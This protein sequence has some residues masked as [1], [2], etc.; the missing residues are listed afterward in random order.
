MIRKLNIVLF[1][2]FILQF[3]QA[4]MTDHGV[5]KYG[6]EWI[7][8]G[9]TYYKI[10]IWEDGIY[11]LDFQTLKN[12]GISN[13]I[14][15]SSL[16]LF[17]NGN[18]IPISVNQ[19]NVWSG[20]DF[21]TFNGYYNKS[22]I[23][24]YSFPNG[25]EDIVNP[26]ASMYSDTAA[27]FLTINTQS[28]NL[29][30]VMIS[31]DLTNLPPP[32]PFIY[33]ISSLDFKEVCNSKTEYSRYVLGNQVIAHAYIN[34]P[35]TQGKGMI[36]SGYNQTYS[37]DCPDIT[38]TS[39]LPVYTLRGVTNPGDINLN[40]GHNLK[41]YLGSQLMFNVFSPT[42]KVMYVNFKYI[43]T[44]RVIKAVENRFT[45]V[46]D[47]GLDLI[48]YG[49]LA[50][51][52]T[53]ALE[54]R[55]Q[56]PLKFYLNGNG[57]E[58]Y[59]EFNLNSV[60][61]QNPYLTDSLGTWMMSGIIDA[62]KLK[63]KL[64]PSLERQSLILYVN[65]S[66]V[67]PASNIRLTA[68]RTFNNSEATYIIV[69]HP[70]LLNNNNGPSAVEEYAGYRRSQPGGGHDVDVV[71]VYDLYNSF[72][73]GLDYNPMAVKNYAN[74]IVLNNQAKFL[75]IIGRGRDY[76][77]IRSTPDLTTA[78][79]KGYGVPSFGDFG[80]DNLLV[81]GSFDRLDM[82]LA[83]GRLPAV[84]QEE[85]RVYLNKIKASDLAYFAPGPNEDKQWTKQII[86]LNG[87]NI[88]GSDQA[89]IK[90]GQKEA[91]EIIKSNKLA[92][93]VTT[94]VKGSNQT[95][96]T[97]SE[98]YFKLVNEGVSIV[99][100]FGHGALSSLEYPIDIPS[101][102]TN[103]PRLPI[104]IIKGCKTGNCQ[105]DGSSIPS[106]FLYED[107]YKTT[108]FRAVI[109]SISDSELYSL[110]SM[111]KQFYTLL[112]G[113]LYGKSFGEVFQRTFN[114]PGLNTS[115]ESM[116]QLFVG[117]PAISV[118]PF[119]GPDF[120]VE[121]NSVKTNPES[122][123]SVDNKFEVSFNIIN[124]GTN[125]PDT[126]F[127]TVSYENP[128][129][130]IV[131]VKKH[132]IINPQSTS[133]LQ[134]EFELDKTAN[135]GESTI[136]ITVDPDNKIQESV[137]PQA[138][139]NNEFHN[140][141]GTK[142]F[143]FFIRSAVIVPV[144]PFK[145]S[146]VDTNHITISA[147]S[148]ALTS[149]ARNY[150][151][152]LDTTD[153]FNSPLLE[154]KVISSV[155][156]HLEWD[157]TDILLENQVYFWK[158]TKDSISPLEPYN[159]A[160][161][162]FTYNKD[163]EGFSQSHNGQFR[164]DMTENLI[165]AGG[166]NNMR[167]ALR[168]MNFRYVSGYYN[169]PAQ[170]GLFREGVHVTSGKPQTAYSSYP[171]GLLGVM[172]Y[173]KDSMFVSYPT[174]S[175][176]YG[177]L[178]A[179]GASNRNYLMFEA[180]TYTGRTS[181]INFIENV[182]GPEDIVIFFTYMNQPTSELFESEWQADSITN[183][184]KNIF[185]IIEQYGGTK[186]RNLVNKPAPYLIVFDKAKGT[187]QESISNSG[188]QIEIEANT[189]CIGDMGRIE[190]TF[191]PAADWEL[192]EFSPNDS[193]GRK[194]NIKIVL[195]AVHKSNSSLNYTISEITTNELSPISIDLK[196][197]DAP[198]FP[199][200]TMAIDI[201][202]PFLYRGKMDNFKYLR[203]IGGELPEATLLNS[204][205]LFEDDSL[206]QGQNFKFSIKSKNIGKI[207]M[208]SMLVKY[209]IR[210]DKE[211]SF[212]EITRYEPL[213]TD[214]ISTY[215]FDFESKSLTGKYTFIC[216]MN[217]GD[218][219]PEAF[220]GNNIFTRQLFVQGDNQNPLVDATFDGERIFN[221][222]IVSSKPLIRITIRDENK[223]FPLDD[224]G[225]FNLTLV[226]SFGQDTLIPLTSSEIK[227]FPADIANLSKK[228]EA[229][230]EYQPNFS[231]YPPAFSGDGEFSIRITATDVAGNQ[232]GKYDFEK[233]FRII[234]KKSV[235][236]V[237]NYPNPFSNATRFVFTLTGFELPTYY[238]IQIMSIS[239]K[240]VREITQDELGTL[241]IGKHLTDFV[242]DGT[243][244]FGDKLANGIYLYRMIIRD[245]NKKM[246]EKLDE[247]LSTDQF[248][249][250]EW[251]KMVIIR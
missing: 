107:S 83:V 93:F 159:I 33:R 239:G 45:L 251:N 105:R 51:E 132:F 200:I 163:K 46:N 127:Y 10:K 194:D 25:T 209:T 54:I 91:E 130:K 188:E 151:F 13:N 187:I 74:Y 35:F 156:G 1:L 114:T 134:V 85:V 179:P 56:D 158:V 172:W 195:T 218:D 103:D 2:L 8:E 88:G 48:R 32:E 180:K 39:V 222:D 160:S 171:E 152:S 58:R 140:S 66:V 149:I 135:V 208:D 110:S 250:G 101:K 175:N 104:L 98:D 60:I 41:F 21:L 234:N 76:K 16:Q 106:K 116:Q 153:A 237:F 142:G 12:A 181:L 52:Y 79:I 161:S 178:P 70:L 78:I 185:N 82:K 157:P 146:I 120:T 164:E 73:Y 31:N 92:G 220:H 217:P 30:T 154:T 113:E 231:A 9:Q 123:S 47:H 71:N 7:I 55:N 29:R 115:S 219:Q 138:E 126:L 144:Y 112:G 167:F 224:P 226:N 64:P 184:G 150:T 247:G 118:L 49:Y 229:V 63:F 22:E 95:I 235:S 65:N 143:R 199:H 77:E 236:N 81:S 228:N 133:S 162:S 97:A 108:G 89:A 186:I 148:Q 34:T 173:R 155:P 232:S 119:P 248:F 125:Y 227:F 192:F 190:Q 15:G 4:Q 27:Y 37:L 243:D 170:L 249:D 23:D 43:D 238:K 196:S 67:K 80:S 17:K 205:M 147:F 244:Q 176:P 202:D 214:S 242:W 169:N 221:G 201:K 139:L 100:Y 38:G 109:G 68:L 203:F 233:R 207:P 136:F 211:E 183:N 14:I 40:L 96:G 189:L 94:F 165:I 197:V 223:L 168:P 84:L 28:A 122:I 117:D 102:Y 246:Y 193:V 26:K 59:L 20:S 86:Q 210:S 206:D 36:N 141:L 240:V 6:N 87:G 191:G 124:L 166:G 212:Q 18:E 182:V 62:G 99:D 177:S 129:K 128:S 24:K 42:Q 53:S 225:L 137:A 69:S 19:N 230:I 174:N 245:Q 111:A 61:P 3:S 75:F 241:K 215:S 90:S 50:I 198:I 72:C 57:T 204:E 131:E 5:T 145:Y 11:K 213:K 216:E 121:S 44:N